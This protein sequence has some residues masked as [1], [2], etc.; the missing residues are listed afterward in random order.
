MQLAVLITL[1]LCEFILSEW[2]EFPFNLN[3]QIRSRFFDTCGNI[4]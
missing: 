2:K 4:W 1:V 3:K